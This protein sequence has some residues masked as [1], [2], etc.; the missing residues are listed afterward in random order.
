MIWTAVRRRCVGLFELTGDHPGR[1]LPMEG[2]RGLAVL[3][4]FFVHFQSLSAP[5][6]EQ[7]SGTAQNLGFLWGIGHSGVDLFFV[8]SGFLIYGTVI[9]R[10]SRPSAFF[11]RRFQRI[12]PAFLAVFVLYVGLSVVFPAVSKIPEGGENAL[13]YLAE[14]LMLL[15]GML[16]IEPLLTVAWSLSYE[17]F[18]YLAIPLV[19]AVTRMWRW[20]PRNRIRFFA[21]SAAALVALSFLTQASHVRLLM[22]LSGIL[23]Y[24]FSRRDATFGTKRSMEWAVLALTVGGVAI[25]GALEGVPRAEGTT[26]SMPVWSEIARVVVL[27]TAF[28]ALCWTALRAGHVLRRSLSWTPLRWLGNMSYSYYLVHGLALQFVFLVLARVSPSDHH[29]TGMAWAI[30]PVALVATLVPAVALFGLVEKPLSLAPATSPSAAAPSAT[31][32]VA[33]R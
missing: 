10:R 5:W 14:N 20:S 31:A 7:G 3:L 17:V 1:N 15:P 9:R 26:G 30:L 4:V 18:Y 11:R 2:L 16:P 27:G 32:G 13:P 25:S 21:G 22:F 28:G 12:Y 8:L 29:W 23:V 19:V 33:V 24:E 6:I